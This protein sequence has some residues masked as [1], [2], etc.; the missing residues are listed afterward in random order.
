MEA[1]M[2]LVRLAHKFGLKP[3]APQW[4][5]VRSLKPNRDPNVETEVGESGDVVLVAPLDQAAGKFWGWM[6]KR[7]QRPT[8]KRFELEQVG[9]FVWDR[10]DGKR[11][12]ETIARDIQKEFKLSR[13][14]SETALTAFLDMLTKRG[15]IRWGRN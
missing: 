13:T 10:I 7:S 2:G 4:Q 6:A 5:S 1:G 12:V 9:A 15:L 8:F 11:T 14:E 3:Q